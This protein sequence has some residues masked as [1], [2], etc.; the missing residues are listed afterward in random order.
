MT[1]T[2]P[3]DKVKVFPA[4][5]VFKTPS[6]KPFSFKESVWFIQHLN[7][8]KAIWEVVDPF[9]HSRKFKKEDIV[10]E[11][12]IEDDAPALFIDYLWIIYNEDY[13]RENK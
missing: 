7:M 9:L 3:E 5:H 12:S 10:A 11:C 2:I 4:G 1:P 13:R 6:G 8:R